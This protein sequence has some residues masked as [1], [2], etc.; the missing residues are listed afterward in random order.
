M[1]QTIKI[2]ILKLENRTTCPK[3]LY[4]LPA[5]EDRAQKA[6]RMK[7]H[8]TSGERDKRGSACAAEV[9]ILAQDRL[10][11]YTGGNS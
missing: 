5:K 9:S 10:Q 8:Q 6:M 4:K 3:Y 2:L 7:F 1:A 11:G